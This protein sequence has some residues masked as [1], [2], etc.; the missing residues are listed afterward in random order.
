MGSRTAMFGKT[1][2]GKSNVVKM[3][4]QS[5]IETTAKTN[6]VGQLIFDINGENANDNPQDG[7]ASLASAYKDR[8]AV[9]ALTPKAGTPSKPLKLNFY[10][11]APGSIS[12]NPA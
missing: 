4:A 12:A 7:N 11:H 10:E 3:I 9:F 5:L 8:C 2:L 1:R 6:N